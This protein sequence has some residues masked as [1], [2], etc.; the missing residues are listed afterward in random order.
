MWLWQIRPDYIDLCTIAGKKRFSVGCR[1]FLE[2]MTGEIHLSFDPSVHPSIHPSGMCDEMKFPLTLP[3]DDVRDRSFGGSSKSVFCL[4]KS[5]Q[6][7]FED[8]L[9]ALCGML[10]IL[11]QSMSR[12][13]GLQFT[14][15]P[16]LPVLFGLATTGR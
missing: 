7:Y 3:A 6:R 15:L 12:F 8:G 11:I 10:L 9:K 2:D 16:C 4:C 13:T 1:A 14:G 5:S